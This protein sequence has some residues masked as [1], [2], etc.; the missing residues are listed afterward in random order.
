VSK[1]EG[2]LMFWTLKSPSFPERMIK[3]PSG[4]VSC[5]FSRKNP[6][7][8]ATG[9]YD[10]VVAIYDLRRKENSPVLDS[11]KIVGKHI[12]TVWETKW[13][14]RGDKGETLISIASDGRVVEWSM[15][16]GLELRDLLHIKKPTNPN[17]KE[18]KESTVF[19]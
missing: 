6:N 11:S 9:S 1:K 13:V 19:R 5:Q 14:N 12:D 8:I 18:D 3:A 16:K 2:L 7:L 17:Q 4:I 15:K 10:G